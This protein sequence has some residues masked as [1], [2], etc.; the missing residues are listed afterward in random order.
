MRLR[1]G[2]DGFLRVGG[3]LFATATRGRWR[4]SPWRWEL[5]G[6]LDDPVLLAA[7]YAYGQR[8]LDRA[9][10]VAWARFDRAT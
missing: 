9:V 2:T 6:G 10:D 7:G 8:W 5:W 4:F 3:D 1:A